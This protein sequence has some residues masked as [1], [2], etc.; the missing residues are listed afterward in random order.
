MRRGVEHLHEPI[1]RLQAGAQHPE[2]IVGMHFFSPVE[3]M[4]LLEVIRGS[5][6]AD[7]VTATTVHF[8]RR[9]GKTVIVVSDAPGFWINRIL[10]PYM[11]EAGWLLTEGVSV[12]TRNAHMLTRNYDSLPADRH[13]RPK[14]LSHG[15]L[16]H[17]R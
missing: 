2:R 7:W 12:E 5:E 1:E 17:L 15:G 13:N 9:L 4:P 10:A 8:G 14:P 16:G 6:T 11:N 3:K